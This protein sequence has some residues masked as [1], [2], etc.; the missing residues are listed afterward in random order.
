[1]ERIP[2]KIKNKIPSDTPYCYVPTGEGGVKWSEDYKMDVSYYKIKT[3]PFYEHKED[4]EGYCKLYKCE[5]MDQVKECDQKM[6][7]YD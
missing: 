1:M 3:C 7:K 6:G 5:I 4:I 2:R